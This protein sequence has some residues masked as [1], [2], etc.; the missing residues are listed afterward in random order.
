M[1]NPNATCAAKHHE[2]DERRIEE[3]KS[4]I[5]NGYIDRKY[6]VYVYAVGNERIAQYACEVL[7]TS[8]YT[9]SFR[10]KT[11]NL[12]F[13]AICHIRYKFSVIHLV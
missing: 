5:H 10:V 3:K 2:I 1:H 11:L 12:K 9:L 6:G 7:Q 4:A 13:N 8:K